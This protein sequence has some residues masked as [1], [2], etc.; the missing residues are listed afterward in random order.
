MKDFVL[1]FGPQYVE[2][3]DEFDYFGIV[4]LTNLCKKKMEIEFNSYIQPGFNSSLQNNKYYLIP[5]FINKGR[6]LSYASKFMNLNGFEAAGDSL[7]DL[8]MMELASFSHIS[9]WGELLGTKLQFPHKAYNKHNGQLA[10]TG[11]E[12]MINF[13]QR[14]DIDIHDLI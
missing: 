8:T 3:T 7:P 2:K 9:P 1:N 5:N 13:C 12:I 11:E 10:R 4:Y 14:N 6:A